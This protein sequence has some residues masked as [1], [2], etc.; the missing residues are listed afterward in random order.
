LKS[1]NL[2]YLNAIEARMAKLRIFDTTA[3]GPK[4][5]DVLWYVDNGFLKTGKVTLR[6][7]PGPPQFGASEKAK[8]RDGNIEWHAFFKGPVIGH[9]L[10]L[11]E[12]FVVYGPPTM[13]HW[14]TCFASDSKYL[15]FGT[16]SDGVF[17]Y[18]KTRQFLKQMPSAL[19]QQVAG[20]V[21][22]LE[23]VGSILVVNG[24]H[25]FEVPWD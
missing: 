10:L 15:W 12:S 7:F 24:T 4:S 17:Q 11:D 23:L 13:Y 25:Q 9:D 2:V 20:D 18:D 16:R 6:R 3:A 19:L 1:G 14:P 22:T 8:L 5:P 21:D